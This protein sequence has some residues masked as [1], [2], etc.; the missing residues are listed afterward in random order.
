[1]CDPVE[2]GKRDTPIQTKKRANE[3]TPL[4]ALLSENRSNFEFFNISEKSIYF[5]KNFESTDVSSP[6]F[7][8]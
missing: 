5:D 6:K 4:V 2:A 8:K 1:M 3:S 7:S